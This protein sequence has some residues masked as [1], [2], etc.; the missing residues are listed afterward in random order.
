MDPVKFAQTCERFRAH[1]KRLKDERARSIF[2]KEAPAV[3]EN[4]GVKCCA[5][6]LEGRQCTFNATKGKF[7]RKHFS[8]V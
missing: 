6:T 7:C 4:R 5:K 2:L 8:M 1:A 3:M